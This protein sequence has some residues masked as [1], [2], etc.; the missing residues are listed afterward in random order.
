VVIINFVR[1]KIS[2]QQGAVQFPCTLLI[3][4]TVGEIATARLKL[5][6]IIDPSIVFLAQDVDATVLQS[7][8]S[9]LKRQDHHH[10]SEKVN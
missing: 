3:S 8:P 10:G 4:V 2:N 6:N 1:E 5:S 9:F 7:N